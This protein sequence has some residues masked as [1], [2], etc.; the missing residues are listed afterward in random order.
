MARTDFPRHCSEWPGNQAVFIRISILAV[1]LLNTQVGIFFC[2]FVTAVYFL[3]ACLSVQHDAW[4]FSCECGKNSLVFTGGFVG[5]ANAL[6]GC[7]LEKKE[8]EAGI[9]PAGSCAS[10]KKNKIKKKYGN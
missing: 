4:G 9:I 1:R 8:R 3:S 10:A 6:N 5:S 7:T 2:H